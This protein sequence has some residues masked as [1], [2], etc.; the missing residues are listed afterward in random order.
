MTASREGC[1]TPG[2]GIVLSAT[3]SSQEDPLSKWWGFHGP[4][5]YAAVKNDV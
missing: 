4:E 2:T 3:W 5:Y 1:S